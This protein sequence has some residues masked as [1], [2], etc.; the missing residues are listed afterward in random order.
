MHRSLFAAA[1]LSLLATVSTA[2]AG[3]NDKSCKPSPLHP[4]PVVIVHGRG[5][6]VNGFGTMVDALNHAGY[7]VYGTNYGQTGGTGANGM[8]HL[9]VSAGEIQTFVDHTLADTG[10]TKVDM[11]AHSAGGGVVDNLIL[12]KGGAAKIQRVVSFGGLHHP[13]AHAGAAKFADG[14]LFLPNLILTARKVKPDVT[15]QEVIKS[16]L[17]LYTVG[18]GS[19]AGVDAETAESN[20]ASD[21]F[22]PARRRSISI[23]ARIRVPR[24]SPNRRSKT[25]R[26][27]PSPPRTP[28]PRSRPRRSSTSPGSIRRPATGA[29][30]PPHASRS[31][32][33]SAIYRARAPSRRSW[34]PTWTAPITSVSCATPSTRGS[35][36]RNT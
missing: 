17:A 14:D 34:E 12:K 26:R 23:R 27:R 9:W 5:G 31:A 25:L 2:S 7:C 28:L 18:G 29:V 36:P 8:D 22:D 3:L 20:F 13:Y 1:S 10:A 15:A 6:D 24:R 4:N 19:L 32:R 21:L 11:V 30:P 16:A 33:A 35:R